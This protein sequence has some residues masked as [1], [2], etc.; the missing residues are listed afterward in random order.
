MGVILSVAEGTES[1]TRNSLQD[2]AADL[3]EGRLTVR[4]QFKEPI[5]NPAAPVFNNTS[6]QMDIPNATVQPQK[7]F[8]YTGDS[9]IPQLFVEQLNPE[10]VRVQFVLG[11]KL[12]NLSESFQVEDQGRSL[13]FHIF[14]KEEDVLSEFLERA[15]DKLDLQE[16]LDSNQSSSSSE[17]AADSLE[18]IQNVS[19]VNKVPEVPGKTVAQEEPPAFKKVSGEAAV[20]LAKNRQEGSE[21]PLDLVSTTVKTFAMFALVLGLMFLVFYLFKRFV[22]KNTVFGG[23]DKLIQVLGTGFLGPKKNIVL[24]EVAGEVLVLGMSNDNISLLSQIQD[25]EKI[26][27]IKAAAGKEN[28]AGGLWPQRKPKLPTPEALPSAPRSSGGFSN[29]LK[30]FSGP[31]SEKDKSVGEVTGQIRKNLAKLRTL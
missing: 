27:Q 20:P 13:I 25:K 6:V 30:Q 17:P 12:T 1:A 18:E 28:P 23:N 21:K 24:V 8:V 7:R 16:E 19:F 29:Y 26:E 4:L 14:K 9:R 15:A 5:V 22:L 2:I 31:V 3:K 10:T 11:Q